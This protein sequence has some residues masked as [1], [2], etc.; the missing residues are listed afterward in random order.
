MKSTGIQSVVQ[1]RICTGRSIWLADNPVEF[2][3]EY[4]SL[5]VGRYVQTKVIRVRNKDKPWFDDQCRHVL[6]S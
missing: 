3:N 4:L 1:Y 2:L 6:D 5:L